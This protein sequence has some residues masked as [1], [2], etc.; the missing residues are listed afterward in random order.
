[1]PAAA[2]KPTRRNTSSVAVSRA[3]V[4]RKKSSSK[5]LSLYDRFKHLI[6]TIDGPGDLSTRSKT[7]EG[8]GQFRR[9]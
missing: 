7:M 4:S 3:A 5:P 8:Y 1:M 6:G 2:S 9:P